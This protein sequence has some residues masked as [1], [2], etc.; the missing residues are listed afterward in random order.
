[1]STWSKG[2]V[3]VAF[4][5]DGTLSIYAPDSSRVLGKAYTTELLEFFRLNRPKVEVDF[6]PIDNP[7][8]VAEVSPLDAL[9]QQGQ[10]IEAEAGEVANE[11][12]KPRRGRPRKD[13]P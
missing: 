11:F 3:Q 10:E 5:E 12:P 7:E 8:V 13:Q 1:M 9:T 2:G 4:R 6:E